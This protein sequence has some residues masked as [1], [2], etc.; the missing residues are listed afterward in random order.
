MKPDYRIELRVY[1]NET[2][3]T[4]AREDTFLGEPGISANAFEMAEVC[5]GSLER[6]FPKT[7]ARHLSEYYSEP[8]NDEE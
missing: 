2:G 4:I 3:E 5:L 6:R 7:H 1:D 8:D